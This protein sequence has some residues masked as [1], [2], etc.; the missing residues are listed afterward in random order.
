[1]AVIHRVCYICSQPFTCS[2]NCADRDK[3]NDDVYLARLERI[4]V[5]TCLSCLLEFNNQDGKW[6]K[7]FTAALNKNFCKRTHTDPSYR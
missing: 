5:C 4:E 7:E 3:L 2:G 1:M 6:T